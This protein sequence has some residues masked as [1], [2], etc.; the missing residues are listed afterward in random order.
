MSKQ[1]YFMSAATTPGLLRDCYIANSSTTITGLLNLLRPRK[2]DGKVIVSVD[3]ETVGLD[4]LL[5]PNRLRLLQLCTSTALVI[6]DVDRIGPKAKKQIVEFLE[7]PNNVK[8]FHNSKFDLKFLI[9][10]LN[11]GDLYPLYDTMIADQILELGHE[12]YTGEDGKQHRVKHDLA[13]VAHKLLGVELNKDIEHDWTGKLTQAQLIYAANDPVHLLE[14]RKEQLVRA[15]ELGLLHAF[16]IE[17]E[18]CQPTA[19]Q[20]L[21]GFLLNQDKWMKL[22]AKAKADC[23]KIEDQLFEILEPQVGDDLLLFKDAVRPFNLDSPEELKPRLEALGIELPQILDKKTNEIKD[24]TAMEAMAE[25]SHTHPIIKLIIQH[26]KL[27]KALTSYGKNF[28]RWINPDGRAHADVRQIGTVTTRNSVSEPP[29][30]GIPKQSDHRE[31]FVAAPGSKLVWA[32]YSQIELR[33]LAEFSGDQNMLKAFLGGHDLHRFTASLVF[34]IPYD[35]VV[36]IQRRRA[37][38]LNFGIVYGV[39]PQRF[40]Q[41]GGISVDEAKR[42]MG[43]YARGYKQQDVY[44]KNA[45]NFGRQN[46][47]CNTASGK[48]INFRL[49]EFPNTPEGQQKR[50]GAIGAIERHSKNYPIQGTSA[51]ITKTALRLIH[52]ELVLIKRREGRVEWNNWPIKLVHVIHDEIVLEAEDAFV[53]EAKAILIRCMVAAGEQFLKTV[54]VI[55]DVES[56][57]FWKK[58]KE[59]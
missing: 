26:R 1:F 49:Q 9:V 23:Y 50:Q 33:I 57:I 35:S 30:H 47:F 25:I 46:M 44:L 48:I 38:D 40:A 43:D 56:N 6:F 11:V 39:G 13:T 28:L 37:K 45:A 2:T 22:D 32:D 21:N 29:L 27:R 18:A 5:P 14:M 55:V 51:D 15:R 19:Q 31:C 7:D 59:D 54:P 20:E 34:G 52:D 16:K 12:Y 24:T 8:V 10:W 17:F 4:P 41:K 42:L 58:A 53:K 3:T 36:D